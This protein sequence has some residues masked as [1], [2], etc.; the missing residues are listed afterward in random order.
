MISECKFY[1]LECDVCGQIEIFATSE[2]RA[3]YLSDNGW[4]WPIVKGEQEHHCPRC[5]EW[6]AD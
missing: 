6:G 1:Y 5:V 4:K 3:D 2:Q